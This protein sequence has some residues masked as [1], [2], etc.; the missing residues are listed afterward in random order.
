MKALITGGCGFVGS[1]LAE[2]LSQRNDQLIIVD[3]LSMGKVENIANIKCDLY[4]DKVQNLNNNL[5]KNIDII[6]H[7]AAQASAP[8]S[9]SQFFESSTN[10]LNSSLKIIEISRLYSIPIVYASSS[11]IYGNLDLGDESI[12]RIE[13]LSPYALDKL[14]LEQYTQMAFNLYGVRSI[15]LRFFNIYGPKQDPGSP[16]SGVISLFIDRMLRKQKITVNGGYQ[17]RDFI[18]IDDVI[19]VI[20]KS[21]SVLFTKKICDTINCGTGKSISI[22]TL[23]DSLSNYLDYTPEIEYKKLPLGDPEVSIGNYGKLKSILKI[24]VVSFKPINYGL[25][26]TIEYYKKHLNEF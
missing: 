24:D 5:F 14:V 1:N 26:K 7:L 15:G 13:N 8:L 23:V 19:D 21:S 6:F 9:I 3:N 12:N 22:D 16:Y 2:K 20:I 25:P 10:N 11:A 4:I 17:T 18:Y